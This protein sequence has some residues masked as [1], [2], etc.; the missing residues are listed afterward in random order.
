MHAHSTSHISPPFPQATVAEN[1]PVR[2]RITHGNLG[3]AAEQHTSPA[4]TDAAKDTPSKGGG[5]VRSRTPVPAVRAALPAPPLT[6]P[7]LHVDPVKPGGAPVRV[8][9]MVRCLATGRTSQ[10]ASTIRPDPWQQCT[11]AKI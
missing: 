10:P 5:G 9:V 8:A 2:E 11:D 7:E 3:Q 1:G 6:A 4:S